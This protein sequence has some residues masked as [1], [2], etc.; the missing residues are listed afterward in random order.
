MGKG[1]RERGSSK[2]APPSFFSSFSTTFMHA[3]AI[4]VALMSLG[5]A[6]AVGDG[7]TLPVML[8]LTSTIFNDFGNGPASVSDFTGT[9]NK[10]IL[11]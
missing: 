4:D 1:G 5:F 2:S 11:L 8:Y 7:V 10:V 9:I 3:D 6:G